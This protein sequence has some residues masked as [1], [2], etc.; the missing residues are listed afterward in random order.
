VSE[1]ERGRQY[2][3]R[4][5]AAFLTGPLDVPTYAEELIKYVLP[6]KNWRDRFNRAVLLLTEGK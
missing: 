6:D 1:F 3:V 5:S 2:G 4:Q